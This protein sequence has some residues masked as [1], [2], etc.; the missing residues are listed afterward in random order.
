MAI[1]RVV[2]T[3]EVN[4]R[5]WIGATLGFVVVDSERRPALLM[6]VTESDRSP[7]IWTQK[8]SE[9]PEAGAET[10]PTLTLNEAPAFLDDWN[11][12]I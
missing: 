9:L 8:K 12:S 10:P 5:T 7:L 3:D 6:V 11:P 2:V 1:D 4:Q